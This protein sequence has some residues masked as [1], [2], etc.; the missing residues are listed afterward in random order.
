MAGSVADGI[1]ALRAYEQYKSKVHYC[2]AENYRFEAA[3]RHAAREVRSSCGQ[4]LTANM[5]AFVPFTKDSKY[6][7]TQW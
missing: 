2:V 7:K 1:Q 6:E 5:T 4:V 3:M